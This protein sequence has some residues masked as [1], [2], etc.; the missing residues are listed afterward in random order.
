[1]N[2][3]RMASNVHDRAIFCDD[4]RPIQRRL[5]SARSRMEREM[6]RGRMNDYSMKTLRKY[7][8]AKVDLRAIAEGYRDEVVD[9]DR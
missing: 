2:C 3:N 8:R 4:C 6:K 5:R 1:M 9:G 7:L